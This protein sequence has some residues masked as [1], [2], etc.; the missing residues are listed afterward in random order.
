MEGQRTEMDVEAHFSYRNLRVYQSARAYV[1]YVYGLVD[2]YF[3]DYEKYALS[4]QLRRSCTSVSFNIAE[5]TGRF[6]IREQIH[7]IEIAF[8]SLYESM[9]QLELANDLGYIQQEQLTDTEQQVLVI[10]KQLSGFRESK[11]K[12]LNERTTSN[13]R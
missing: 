8:G 2:S 5:S 9:S 4:D 12:Q 6:S 3:P 11:I 10:A 7:F 1:K 13:N